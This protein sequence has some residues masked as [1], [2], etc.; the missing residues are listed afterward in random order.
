MSHRIALVRHGQTT[1]S[2]SGQHTST[3]DIDLTD[4]GVHQAMTIPSLLWGL[5]LAPATVWSSPRLRAQRTAALAGLHVNAIVDDLAEWAYGDY[6]GITSKQIHQTDPGWSVFISGAPG[7]ETPED[8]AVR[9]DRVLARAKDRLRKGDVALFC[10]G[11]ISRVL[12]MRW[13][14]LPVVAGGMI[15]MNPGAV[16]VLGTYHD[17]P[18]IEHANVVPFR[19]PFISQRE[20]DDDE[21]AVD[22]GAGRAVGADTADSGLGHA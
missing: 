11:H 21:A 13:V 7:G 15:L 6:E 18:C 3:T 20:D 12:A 2:K 4:E 19:P 1:W 9:C 22:S 14:G 8:V 5:D 10:H 17:A 16:T